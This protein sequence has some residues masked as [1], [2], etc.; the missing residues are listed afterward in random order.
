MNSRRSRPW[1]RALLYGPV[2]IAISSLSASAS[3]IDL[4]AVVVATATDDGPQD[5]IFDSF[6]PLNLGSVNNNGF[7]SFRSC[8]RVRSLIGG[9]R[10]RDRGCN[11]ADLSFPSSTAHG[12]SRLTVTRETAASR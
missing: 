3:V 6:P 5:G 9:I 7:E 1:I 10:R 4:N 11:P 12:T 8:L 2:L